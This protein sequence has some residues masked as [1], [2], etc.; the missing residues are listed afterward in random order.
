MSKLGLAY[1]STLYAG[2]CCTPRMCRTGYPHRCVPHRRL[3]LNW[4]R[5]WLHARCTPLAT[6]PAAAHIPVCYPSLEVS[7]GPSSGLLVR[8]LLSQP[9][10]PCILGVWLLFVKWASIGAAIAIQVS[11]LHILLYPKSCSF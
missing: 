2:L 11:F 4:T 1:C 7:A 8:S 5:I 9:G 6:L 3:S 10:H